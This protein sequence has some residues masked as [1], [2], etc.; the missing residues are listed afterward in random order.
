MKLIVG[1]DDVSKFYNQATW[2]GADGQA[3]RKLEFGLAV[4]GTDK[5]L[6]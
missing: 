2:S 3:G 6:P 1:D 5:N 4:S